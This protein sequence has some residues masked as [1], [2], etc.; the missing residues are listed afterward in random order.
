MRSTAPHQDI[1]EHA[2]Q[3][4]ARAHEILKRSHNRR[5]VNR[6]TVAKGYLEMMDACPENVDCA[7][8]LREA[9]NELQV[10]IDEM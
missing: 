10:I 9:L 5:L 7:G 6:L 8:K 4:V 3:I 1:L 2:H